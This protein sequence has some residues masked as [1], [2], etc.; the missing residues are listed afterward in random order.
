MRILATFRTAARALGRNK[1]R[2]LLTMLG[3]I[4]GV[5]A[6][7]AM[8]CISSGAKSQIEAQI[9]SMRQNVVLVF[10]GKVNRGGVRSGWGWA[11]TLK[12]ED[13][14]AIERE[15]LGVTGVSPEV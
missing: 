11:P 8:V 1:L 6:V 12:I 2:T 7:I 3:M 4:I 10:A 15:V 9:G 14:Q 13:A 5:G